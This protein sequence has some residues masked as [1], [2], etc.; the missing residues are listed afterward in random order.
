VAVVEQHID[1]ATVLFTDVVGSTQMRARIGEE[2]AEDL[3][4]SHDTLVNDAIVAKRGTVVKHTGDGVMA[5][6]SAAVDAVAAAVAIQQAVDRHNKRAATE[7]LDVRVGISVGDVTFD[8]L[9]CFGLPVIEAQ[10]LE[11][12]AEGGQILCA[13]LV[14][15][16]A[17]GRGGHDFASLGDLEL[18]GI[19]EPVPTV[20]VRWEP[21]VQAVMPRE[22]PLPATLSSPT[23]FGLAG[24]ATEFE[25]LIDAWKEA[26]TGRR[27]VV[28]LAGEPGIGKT[29]LAT[30]TALVAREQGALVLA[31]RCDEEL[32]MPYQPFVEA[33]RFQVDLGDELPLAWLG[34][35]AGELT[36]LVPELSGH[37]A[38]LPP[39]LSSDPESER[40]RLF[41]AV[42]AWLHAT[43]SSVPVMLVLD[44][45]HWADRPTL[46]L[47]RHLVRE[48]ANDALLIVG[49]YRS[50][51]LD[52]AHPLAATL[53]DLRREGSVE[54][55]ALDGLTGDGVADFLGGAAGH[56]L[57]EAGMALAQAVSTE[58]GGNPFFVGEI[59]RHLVESGALVHRDGRWVSDLTLDEIG[60]PEGVREV[61]GRR[62]SRLD[63]ETQRLLSVAAVMG[64]EF[65]LPVLAA[66]ADVTVD[67]ALD[68]LD[69]ALAAGLVIEV[70]LDRYRFGH[71]LLR[72]TL[73]E[74][75]T[76]SRRVR[77][78]RKIAEII[79]AKHAADL[80]AAVTEL[81]YHYG[82]AA[83]GGVAEKAVYYASRAGDLATV[84]SAPGDAA[85]W[86][87]LALEYLEL[88]DGDEALE[89]DLLTRLGTA[90]LY[91]GTGTSTDTLRR[92]AVVA[93]DARLYA[94]MAE[95][96]VVSGRT[97]FDSGQASDPLKIEMLEHVLDHLGDEPALRARALGALA[98]ELIFVGDLRRD[99]LLDEAVAIADASGDPRAIVEASVCW[100][101]AHG[102]SSWSLDAFHDMGMLSERA[103][104]AAEQLDDT[105]LLTQVRFG[106]C[107]RA[108]ILG[109]RGAL[110]SALAELE[111][112]AAE[113][114]HPL[115]GRSL[116]FAAQHLAAVD[117][118]LAEAAALS[119]EQYESWRAAGVAEAS[120]YRSVQQFVAAREQARLAIAVPIFRPLVE[121]VAQPAVV[122][123]MMA[124]ALA[125][126]GE[127]DEAAALLDLTAADRFA[128]VPDDAAWPIAIGL[129]A[130]VAAGVGSRPVA[131]ELVEILLPFDGF[132]QFGT[133]G[134]MMGPSARLLARLE[135]VLDRPDDADRHFGEALAQSVAFE[136]PLWIARCALDWAESLGERG[137]ASR[138]L[139][140]VDQAEGAMAGLSLPA[141]ELQVVR[142]RARL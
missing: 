30:E 99:A 34:P 53:A 74:E 131:A 38:G 137:E 111:R 69:A 84:A 110:L 90:Q 36:R 15:H 10:R 96:L 64:Y 44:D 107:F 136:S 101:N 77:A 85:R 5:T 108:L 122:R 128:S 126:I 93:R 3:R 29:R 75:L 57:D 81:A 42:T 16:L 1:T 32:D 13:E 49:T 120:T 68:L 134:I 124:F 78:H 72:S 132:R 25:T 47:M 60:L 43:T 118:R 6:F 48:T 19:P 123:S 97:S 2:A 26:A 142:L 52:R 91:A 59:V 63:D 129:S 92:A 55:L 70:G 106:A 100:F 18:K 80:D 119:A 89:V 22:M 133:G 114:Q 31:G 41:D 130:E 7:R 105:T 102:R 58:T 27:R 51:D 109:E 21:A 116:L 140:L 141:L 45:L 88:D 117:G 138:A 115:T 23:G 24:R 125:E 127:L 37:L 14:Q 56:D 8:G 76:T 50:T 113:R 95:A 46:Q 9:D 17:R 20:E 83:A 104:A 71:A 35:L 54:R 66:V 103:S 12:A 65:S 73:L 79:E 40:A 121:E 33:L 94:A 139:E 87:A 67:T 4:V 62:V 86:Y 61:V 39:R 28:L 11:A 135:L 112:L 82:E 98:V